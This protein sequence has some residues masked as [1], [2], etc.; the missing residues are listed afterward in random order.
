MIQGSR[1]GKLGTY[2]LIVLTVLET[3]LLPCLGP[4][5]PELQPLGARQLA[6]RVLEFSGIP[7]WEPFLLGPTKGFSPELWA[8]FLIHE[9]A[10][11]SS[12]NP[13]MLFPDCVL[14]TK[15]ALEMPHLFS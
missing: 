15:G 10:P 12:E 7:S 2:C 5:K 1:V 11:E 9:T 13:R 6:G 14:M 4:K 8:G 3:S